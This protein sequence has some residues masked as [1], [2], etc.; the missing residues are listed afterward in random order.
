MPQDFSKIIPDAGLNNN[1]PFDL[2]ILKNVLQYW[3]NEEIIDWLDNFLQE[4]HYRYVLITNGWCQDADKTR[5]VNNLYHY[6]K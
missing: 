1:G 2:V 5:D 3:S 6:S 4:E